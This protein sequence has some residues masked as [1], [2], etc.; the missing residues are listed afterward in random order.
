[1]SPWADLGPA[2]VDDTPARMFQFKEMAGEKVNTYTF[3]ISMVSSRST[4]GPTL[5]WHTA[6]WQAPS[7]L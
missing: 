6:A 4:R 2:E 3:Y 7:F 1:M 5:C